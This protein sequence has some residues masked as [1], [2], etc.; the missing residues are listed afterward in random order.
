[1]PINSLI[2]T[3]LVH[4]HLNF[5]KSVASYIS[6][7]S[8]RI[9]IWSIAIKCFHLVFFQ[10]FNLHFSLS[11]LCLSSPDPLNSFEQNCYSRFLLLFSQILPPSI[12][13]IIDMI[14][15]G[16]IFLLILQVYRSFKTCIDLIFFHFQFLYAASCRFCLRVSCISHCD[17]ISYSS[18]F[19]STDSFC[20]RGTF[21]RLS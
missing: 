13:L 19:P 1:M 6:M 20:E 15:F 9:C 18:I 4:Q 5:N 3:P 7:F 2:L 21:L 10:F 14:P 17:P 8:L 16:I 12:L 11:C